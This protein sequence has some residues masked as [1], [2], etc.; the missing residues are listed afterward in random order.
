MKK[1]LGAILLSSLMVT[2]MW[3]ALF[4][5]KVT[6]LSI[7]NTGDV[8][9]GIDAFVVKTIPNDNANKKEWLAML[10]TAKTTGADVKIVHD[11]G[12]ISQVVL[13]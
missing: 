1:L 9:V 8:A 5:G 10:L 6:K 3:G 12:I 7:A 2:T 13:P 11:S 4:T